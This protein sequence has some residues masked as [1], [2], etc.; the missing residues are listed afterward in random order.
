[1]LQHAA[2]CWGYSTLGLTAVAAVAAAVAAVTAAWSLPQSPTTTRHK[3]ELGDAP[4]SPDPD[5]HRQP[6]RLLGLRTEWSPLGA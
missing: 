4:V 2:A 3:T 5:L 6:H 1:M